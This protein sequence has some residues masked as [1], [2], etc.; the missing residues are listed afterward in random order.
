MYIALLNLVLALACVLQAIGL[1]LRA[2]RLPTARTSQNAGVVAVILVP[3]A[4][5][6]T[7]FFF[8]AGSVLHY[9]F[10]SQPPIPPEVVGFWL[11]GLALVGAASFCLVQAALSLRQRRA[12][13]MTAL[14]PDRAQEGSV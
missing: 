9:D 14:P 5:V 13:R 6:L 3:F 1:L 11:Y 12:R 10:F 2:R 8:W 4:A 7:G